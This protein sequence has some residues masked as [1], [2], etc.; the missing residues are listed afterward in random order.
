M[1]VLLA[2]TVSVDFLCVIVPDLAAESQ[3]SSRFRLSHSEL[4]DTITL[5]LLSR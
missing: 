3:L 4:S 2:V 1:V 5:P